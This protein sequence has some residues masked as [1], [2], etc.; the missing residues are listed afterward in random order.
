MKKSNELFL[1]TMGLASALMLFQGCTEQK[2]EQALG[3]ETLTCDTTVF[4]K[5]DV[6]SSPSCKINYSLAFFKMR[7]A[8]DSIALKSNAQLIRAI[9][10]GMPATQN[11][12]EFVRH[13]KDT[14]ITNYRQDLE[15]LYEYDLRNG[16][17]D[18]EL[19]G[20]YNYEYGINSTL[21]EGKDHVWNYKVSHFAYTGGAHPNSYQ[22]WFN[23]TDQ[24]EVLTKE[25]VFLPNTEAAVCE[26][27]L[28][29]LIRTAGERVETDTITSIEGLQEYGILQMNGLYLPDNFLLEK[30]GIRFLYNPYDIAPYALGD[31]ELL[32]P[33]QELN[34]YLIKH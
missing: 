10:E 22:K 14:L 20:W 18:H 8:T 33:Y 27:I 9:E 34:T 31:F 5:D 12:Q 29:E 17:K 7:Q 23:L 6:K 28:K 25:Q 16:L 11:P 32:V 3:T 21:T 24:G 1:K 19:P 2:A 30:E 15:G 26:L 4:L 13:L